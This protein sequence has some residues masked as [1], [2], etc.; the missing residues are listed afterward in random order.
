[1][2]ISLTPE[3]EQFVQEKVNSGMYHSAS[4]VIRE[5]LLFL[6]ERDVIRQMRIKELKAEIQKGIDSGC[7]TPLDMEEIIDECHK[8]MD[9]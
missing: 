5:S 6:K 1:M 7:A 3:L 4:D 8:E 2:N 9:T